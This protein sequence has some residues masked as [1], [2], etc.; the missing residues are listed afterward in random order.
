MVKMNWYHL[1]D[2]AKDLKKLINSNILYNIKLINAFIIA[3]FQLPDLHLHSPSSS[4]LSLMKIY[5][6][7]MHT[8]TKHNPQE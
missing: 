1:C 2:S 5:T 7:A 8:M 6:T 3:T 4:M